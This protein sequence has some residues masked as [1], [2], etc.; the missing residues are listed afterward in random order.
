METPP[1]NVPIGYAPEICSWCKGVGSRD[2]SECSACGGK[3]K[4]LARQPAIQ[5]ANINSVASNTAL[6]SANAD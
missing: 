3:G 6:N 1:G 4:V 5:T 2:E